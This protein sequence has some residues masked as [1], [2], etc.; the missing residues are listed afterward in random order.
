ML[1]DWLMIII[2]AIY[3]IATIL[4][5]VFNGSSAKAAKEQTGEMI[6]QYKEENRPIVTV[7]FEVIKAGL[8]C[9]VIRNEGPIAAH[10]VRIKVNQD[11]V[12][13]LPDEF[14]RRGLERLN[15]SVFFLASKQELTLLFGSQLQFKIISK[16]IAK[17]DISY[18]NKYYEYTEIDIKQYEFL[19]LLRTALEDI[20]SSVESIQ[21]NEEK[22]HRELLREM[23]RKPI[24]QQIAIHNQTFDEATKYQIY[25]LLATNSKR[26]TT[27][28]VLKELDIDKEKALDLLIELC[29]VDQLVG[30]IP[31]VDDNNTKWYRK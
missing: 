18:D 5:C 12:D 2:T 21:K 26:F 14:D 11:F 1:T 27:Q 16:I 22:F 17:I 8:L 24:V 3:V 6:R 28:E 7:R 10:D 30:F 29:E 19:I 23:K 9:F 15:N 25:K 4:I 13:N 31:E 20:S